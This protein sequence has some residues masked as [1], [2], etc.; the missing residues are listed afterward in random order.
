MGGNQPLSVILQ[1]SNIVWFV[2]LFLILVT[3]GLFNCSQMSIILL[4]LL[5]RSQDIHKEFAR[6]PRRWYVEAVSASRLMSCEVGPLP[7]FSQSLPGGPTLVSKRPSFPPETSAKCPRYLD[8]FLGS[9]LC[10]CV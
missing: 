3:V 2:V 1:V 4:M 10:V 6:F 9:S 7:S 8:L 5:S